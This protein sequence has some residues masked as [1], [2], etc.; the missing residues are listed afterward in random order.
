[1]EKKCTKCFL[2]L[3]LN[4]FAKDSRNKSGLRAYC[5]NCCKIMR[6]KY[7]AENAE[8]VRQSNKNW[9]L[10]NIERNKE[11]DA[12]KRLRHKNNPFKAINRKKYRKK[13]PAKAYADK[14]KRRATQKRAYPKFAN[15]QIL[16]K[17]YAYAKQ[18]NNQ[19]LAIHVDHIVPLKGK[20]ASGLHV[21][22]NLRILPAKENIAKNN[23][24]L[25][26][27]APSILE[28]TQFKKFMLIS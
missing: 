25:D 3:G 11:I 15:K 28:D 7:Y 16:E 6:D 22:W 27:F 21:E 4:N 26:P 20:T 14:Q 9:K 8:K 13:D 1:M 10:N 24:L 17:I 5:K 18:L 19:G 2:T 23:A 12:A